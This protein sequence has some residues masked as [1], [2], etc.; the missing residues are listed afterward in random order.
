MMPRREPPRSAK[1][2][3]ASDKSRRTT[4]RPPRSAAGSNRVAPGPRPRRSTGSSDSEGRGTKTPAFALGEVLEGI[5]P[6]REALLAG[7]RRVRELWLAQDLDSATMEDLVELGK[8]RRAQVRLV[9]RREI[10]AKAASAVPQ[11]VIARVDSISL[12]DPVDLVRSARKPLLIAL[13]GV[14]DPHNLG[15]VIRTATCFGASG[16]VLPRHGS[17]RITPV[18]AKAAAGGIEWTPLAVVAGLPNTLA[19]LARAGVWIVGL[20]ADGESD[21]FD[22][23]VADAPVCLVVGAEGA[24]LSRLVRARCDVIAKVPMVGQLDSL[25]V[26]VAT[27]IAVAAISRA[28]ATAEA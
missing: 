22:I 25:N 9:T 6:V 7:R 4:G 12:H 19:D 1:S 8:S 27:G 21:V 5:N 3:G 16:V 24:G 26:S 10:D 2:T 15:A 11:G 23:G 20:A 14:T 13:D 28:R 17:A 18:V